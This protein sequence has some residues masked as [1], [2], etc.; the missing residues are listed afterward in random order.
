MK[1]RKTYILLLLALAMVLSGCSHTVAFKKSRVV[2]AA[3]LDMTINQDKNE[4]YRIDLKVENLALP[5][6]L[7]PAK[8]TYVVW[9]VSDMGSF[10]VGQLLLDKKLRG[11]LS[12][13]TPYKPT[14]IRITAEEDPQTTFPG[15]QVDLT[16]EGIELD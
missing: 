6:D 2:P 9:A 14:S 11:N 13:T 16:S 7:I 4:N 8:K 3:E 1:H 15:M 5:E 12:A 10:N